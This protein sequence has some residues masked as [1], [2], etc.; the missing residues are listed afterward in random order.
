MWHVL[1]PCTY[2]SGTRCCMYG[3]QR[4]T[5]CSRIPGGSQGRVRGGSSR[6]GCKDNAP[7][8]GSVVLA[9]LASFTGEKLSRLLEFTTF[10]PLLECA[11]VCYSI[12][13]F[14]VVA[15]QKGANVVDERQL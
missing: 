1:H 2:E 11:N 9:H 5:T 6:E 14:I 4:I 7:A 3:Q 10:K 15:A 12:F 8:T 13:D